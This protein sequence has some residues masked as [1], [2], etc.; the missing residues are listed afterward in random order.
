MIENNVSEFPKIFSFHL[1]LK[2]VWSKSPQKWFVIIMEGKCLVGVLTP[3]EKDMSFKHINIKSLP[4]AIS[5][6]PIL[7]YAGLSV[8]GFLERIQSQKW[9]WGCSCNFF[10]F[11]H[12]SYQKRIVEKS[13]K[14]QNQLDKKKLWANEVQENRR[15]LRLVFHHFYSQNNF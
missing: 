13:L 15:K 2:E 12:L 8:R 4:C 9:L 11:P 7:I 10:Q 5:R 14:R 3:D 6:S 1:K